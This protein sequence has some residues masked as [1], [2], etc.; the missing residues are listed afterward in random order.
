M[1]K[2]PLRVLF[3]CL[4]NICRSPLAEVVVK[5]VAE[6]RGLAD[7]FHFESAG[8]GSWHVG[9]SA[10]PRSAAKALE[11]G[12]SLEQHQAQQ[13]TRQNIQDWDIFVAMDKDNQRSLIRMGA[14]PETVIMMRDFE[15]VSPAPD[16]PDPYYGGEHGFEDA[17]V[18]LQS[19]AQ[20]LLDFLV[21][22]H[23]R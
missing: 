20:G 16:V 23:V 13:I 6:E 19:N 18:M 14:A 7:V 5:A 22:K 3:V 17:Y 4:G 2:Q 21:E 11:K 15:G 8:T 10:D 12:L 1:S 9:G